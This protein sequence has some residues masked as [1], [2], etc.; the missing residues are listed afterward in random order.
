MTFFN[1]GKN[2]KH[3]IFQPG[4]YTRIEKITGEHMGTL[5]Q[6]VEHLVTG[7]GRCLIEVAIVFASRRESWLTQN[8]MINLIGKKFADSTIR[9]CFKDLAVSLDSLDGLSYIDIETI[10]NDGRGRPTI[11]GKLSKAAFDRIFASITPREKPSISHC[12]RSLR[13]GRLEIP[14]LSIDTH[15]MRERQK[16]WF[17]PEEM[18][19]L[20]EKKIGRPATTHLLMSLIHEGYADATEEISKTHRWGRPSHHQYKLIE[21]G[22]EKFLTDRNVVCYEMAITIGEDDKR[23]TAAACIYMF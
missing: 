15:N 9:K 19:C 8:D 22:V 10:K 13:M 12:F 2:I 3:T 6:R 5:E 11:R 21:A 17:P 18:I 20:V 16:L 14:A 1:T 4:I 23:K 7:K